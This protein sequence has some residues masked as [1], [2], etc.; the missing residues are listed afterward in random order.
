MNIASV[1]DWFARDCMHAA[2]ET[3]NPRQRE[4][5]LKLAALWATAA[6]RSRDEASTQSTSP[7]TVSG[8]N[9]GG[10]AA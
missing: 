2:E 8:P 1:Y 7:T 9:S 3:D 4:I 5:L 10:R 6:Q